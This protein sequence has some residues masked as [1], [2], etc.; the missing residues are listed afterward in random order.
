MD[1]RV[2]EGWNRLGETCTFHPTLTVCQNS[3]MVP[4]YEQTQYFLLL[5]NI[6]VSE[7]QG[8]T[9]DLRVLVGLKKVREACKNKY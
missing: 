2:L 4:S 7:N 5:L 9:T 3:F 8:L 6:V 1:L